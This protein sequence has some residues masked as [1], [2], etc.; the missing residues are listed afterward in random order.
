VTRDPSGVGGAFSDLYL[1]V[2]GRPLSL[3]DPSGLLGGFFDGTLRTAE[4]NDVIYQLYFGYGDPRKNYYTFHRLGGS[5]LGIAQWGVYYVGV[6]SLG[7]PLQVNATF[8]GIHAYTSLVDHY[9]AVDEF[10]TQVKLALSY[11]TSVCKEDDKVDLLGY[12]R[13][14]IAAVYL[15]KQLQEAGITV[16]F[17][18]LIDPSVTYSGQDVPWIPPNVKLAKIYYADGKNAGN[19]REFASDYLIVA[20]SIL[21][22][23]NPS[24]TMVVSFHDPNIGHYAAGYSPAAKAFI[25]PPP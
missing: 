9:F 10:N 3:S 4:S 11:I 1:Y 13:G 12:S 18:G 22:A 2:E 14:A 24:A 23:E 16:R 5:S 7:G 17:L 20:H 8:A 25:S 15:A 19:I 21:S 6:C